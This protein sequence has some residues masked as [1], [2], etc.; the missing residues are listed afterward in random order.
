MNKE[1][2]SIIHTSSLHKE[3]Y[4]SLSADLHT[5]TKFSDGMLSP[6]K[7]VNQA[8]AIGLNA[9]AI[10]DHDTIIGADIAANYVSKNN[11]PIELVR[12]M[13]VS[14]QDGHVLAYNIDTPI[15]QNLSLSETIIKIHK[16]KGLV[17][18]PH[19]HSKIIKGIALDKIQTIIDSENPELYLDG[20]E[21]YNAAEERLVRL[22]KTNRIFTSVS[23]EI[24]QFIQKN[25]DNKKLGAL[26][27]NSDTHTDNLGYGITKYSTESVLTA[28]AS[29][30]TLP[31]KKVTSLTEDLSQASLMLYA[32]AIS[33]IFGSMSIFKK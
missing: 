22:D 9:L 20:I 27:A 30:D 21:I 23:P 28:V 31:H 17:V 33:H 12:G 11:L 18:I 13:E 29:R 5:H 3:N 10:T 32:I 2:L 1:Y 7:M 24:I 26:L 6:E 16:Q 15:P 19:P 4:K 8:I 14:S 25:K